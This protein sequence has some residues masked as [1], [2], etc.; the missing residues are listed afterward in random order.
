MLNGKGIEIG[1]P[2][3]IFQAIYNSGCVCDGVNYDIKTV[4]GSNVDTKYKWKNK[5]IGKQ[6]IA[7][8]TN[9]EIITDETYDFV[10]SS[11]NLEHI[12]NPLKAVKEFLRILKKDKSLIILVPCK[13][14]TFNHKRDNTSFEHL[15]EDYQNGVLEDDLTHLQEILEKHDLTRGS[16]AGT[17]AQFKER[18]INNFKNRCLHHQ[19][20]SMELFERMAEYFQLDVL[21]NTVFHQNL[22]FAA[23]KRETRL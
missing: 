3:D 18:S 14:Y 11:N 12:A 4:W 15:L 7:D 10:L 19:V 6:I 13:E 22:Y 21:E 17:M 23:I 20:Y 2:S 1:G 8:A 5:I 9:L 16:A